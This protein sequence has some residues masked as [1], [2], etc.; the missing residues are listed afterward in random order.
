MNVQMVLHELVMVMS[1]LVLLMDDSE[2][3]E[4]QV[5]VMAEGGNATVLL[6]PA[7]WKQL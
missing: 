7:E 5:A 6:I 4:I 3:I 1:E 2:M